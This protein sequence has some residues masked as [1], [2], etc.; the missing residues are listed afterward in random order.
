MEYFNEYNIFTNQTI[1]EYQHY[2]M[3]NFNYIYDYI[4]DIELNDNMNLSPMM[5]ITILSLIY[6]SIVYFVSYFLMYENYDEEIKEDTIN[7]VTCLKV[8]KVFAT[9][10]KEHFKTDTNISLTFAGKLSL[11]RYLSKHVIRK[12]MSIRYL[13][14]TDPITKKTF[15]FLRYTKDDYQNMKIATQQWIIK[16]EDKWTNY[17]AY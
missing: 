17:F 4:N 12:D 9:V 16:K 15:R 7:G 6:V 3:L 1:F 2:K 10:A 11:G 14:D 5:N 8:P 13:T